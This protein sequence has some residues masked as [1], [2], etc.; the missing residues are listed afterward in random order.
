MIFLHFLKCFPRQCGGQPSLHLHDGDL[1]PFSPPVRGSALIK[2]ATFICRFVFPASAG[3]NLKVQDLYQSTSGFPRQCG[4]QPSLL[5]TTYAIAEFSPPVRGST[6]AHCLAYSLIN[7]FPVSAG[8]NPRY[9]LLLTR[10][11]SFPR[12]CG[13]QPSRIA[14]RTPSLTFSPPVRGS[15][16]HSS[17][18]SDDRKVFPAD[19]GVIK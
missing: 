4:G 17:R 12:R 18:S 11:Q 6:L 8:V 5:P 7:V 9:C 19:A 16:Y 15:P 10:L 2:I 3:I 1:L 14:W 13:G